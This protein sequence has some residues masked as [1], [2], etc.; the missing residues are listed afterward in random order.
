MS[1][2]IITVVVC[3]TTFHASVFVCAQDTISEVVSGEVPRIVNYRI[4]LDTV[5]RHDDGRFL[6]FHPRIVS[7]PQPDSNVPAVLMTIQKHLLT[8]GDYYS[9]L[10][11][12][13]TR[14]FG[15]TWSAPEPR[16]ELAWRPESENVDIGVCDVTPGW[17]KPTGKVLAIGTQLRY[18]KQGVQ[19]LDKPGSHSAAYAVY[20]PEGK[21]WSS[22]KTIDM[23]SAD[24]FFLVAPGCVQWVVKPDGTV[25]LPFYTR[26]PEAGTYRS[27]VM[28]CRFDG[29]RLEYVRHG[30]TLELDVDRGLCEPSI[31]EFRGRYLM[32]VRNDQR[33]YVSV[34]DDGLNYS[35][36]TP[37]RFDDGEELGGHN[38]QQHWLAHTD[39]LFLVYTRKTPDNGH[40]FRNRAPL[41]I[42]QVNPRTLRVIR[43][44][45]RVLVPN[46]GATLG[47]FDAAAVS[48]EESWVSVSEGIFTKDARKHGADGSTF[49]ARIRWATPNHRFN[50]SMQT[51]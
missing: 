15:A 19:L 37:W 43:A 45:E 33:N 12:L 25:L 8:A 10:S 35:A 23:P 41:F 28:E 21:A 40:I 26:G 13:R 42:A 7:Y 50:D 18:S 17:H 48:V 1:L 16:P 46:R 9:G 5:V 51:Q 32:T 22:W 47:N 31:I 14:D 44:T 4:H 11:I 2:R 34:S 3:A 29:E 24:E 39:G 36:I 6:W 38:T 27:S 30:N 20:T 49:V